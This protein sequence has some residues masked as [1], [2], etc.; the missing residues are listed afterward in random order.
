[1]H[2]V[3]NKKS[4]ANTL[5]IRTSLVTKTWWGVLRNQEDLPEIW[6][7]NTEVLVGIGGRPL[8]RNR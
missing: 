3:P 5:K 6:L 7:L 2:V 4:L 1:M 8:G